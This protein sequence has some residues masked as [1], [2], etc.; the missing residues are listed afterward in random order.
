MTVAVPK[1]RRC[2]RC[3][4][5][6]PGAGPLAPE[7]AGLGEHVRVDDELIGPLCG[8][9]ARCVKSGAAPVLDSP[10]EW[11]LAFTTDDPAE[12]RCIEGAL[13]AL[14]ERDQ[15]R[16]LAGDCRSHLPAPPRLV[17]RGT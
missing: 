15:L 16:A 11:L 14:R 12:R 5:P 9:C 3:R 13:A 4:D 8:D 7:S 17:T 2:V 1:M 10:T 6:L